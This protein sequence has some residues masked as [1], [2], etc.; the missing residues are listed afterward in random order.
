LIAAGHSAKIIVNQAVGFEEIM[1]QTKRRF[2]RKSGLA[3]HSILAWLW[4]FQETLK[5][6]RPIKS[7]QKE[8]ERAYFNRIRCPL[9]KWH[10]NP[11]HRWYCV[12]CDYPEG[13][14]DGCGTSWNTF[15]TRGRCPGC[16]H[17]WRW[18]TCLR[19]QR[20]SRHEDWYRQEAR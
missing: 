15:V 7:R 8:Q 17:Q 2:Q 1:R 4:L 5:P 12:N 3:S 6:E 11:H 13:F 20:W 10:P 14:N 18:T 9:C 19:C 16:G